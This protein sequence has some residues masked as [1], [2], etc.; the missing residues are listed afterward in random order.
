[1]FGGMRFGCVLMS[2]HTEL[3][4]VYGLII[5]KFKFF[6]KRTCYNSDR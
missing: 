1:M 5:A 2:C 6:A 3:I 4:K